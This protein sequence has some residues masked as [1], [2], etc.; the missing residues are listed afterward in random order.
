V[1]GG[2]EKDWRRYA[3]VRVAMLHFVRV[4]LTVAR[5]IVALEEWVRVPPC[6][7]KV[8]I[9]EDDVVWYVSRLAHRLGHSSQVA[10]AGGTT[11]VP[12]S[13]PGGSIRGHS[14]VGEQCFP[15]FCRHLGVQDK[16][17]VFQV[18]NL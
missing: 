1:S 17:I 6:T 14:S 12:G 2:R 3:S 5:K 7:P 9:V 11:W 4:V 13:N 18:D 10:N 15:K 8:K 16:E